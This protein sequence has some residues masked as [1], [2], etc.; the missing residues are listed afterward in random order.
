ML[1]CWY[2]D[3]KLQVYIWFADTTYKAKNSIAESEKMPGSSVSATTGKN[4]QKD[5]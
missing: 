4:N 1:N 2:D 5:L 3:T